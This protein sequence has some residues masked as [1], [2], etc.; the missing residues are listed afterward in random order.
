MLVLRAAG[1]ARVVV[2]KPLTRPLARRDARL[3][4]AQT[5]VRDP[6]Q[7]ADKGSAGHQESRPSKDHRKTN[8]RGRRDRTEVAASAG[9][10]PTE[11]EQCQ[12]AE[13]QDRETERAADGGQASDQTDRP[14]VG[15]GVEARI[16]RSPGDRDRD[17]PRRQPY[18]EDD[19]L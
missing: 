4:R 11:E 17:E 10:L 6:Q 8:S 1:R 3:E 16:D 13:A 5:R 9:G 18:T 14:A 2:P 19:Q 15:G 12:G 7:D